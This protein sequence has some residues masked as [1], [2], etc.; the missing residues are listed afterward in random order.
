MGDKVLLGHAIKGSGYDEVR[1]AL[2]ILCAQPATAAHVSRQLAQFYVADSPPP[3]L[4]KR[5]VARWG[6]TGGDIAELLNLLFHSPEFKASLAHPLLKDPQH[7]VLSAVRMAY[8]DR[9]IANTQPVTNWLNRLVQPFYGH[10]T[11]DGYPSERVAWNGPGQIEQR[12]EIAQAIGSGSAGL[13]KGEAPAS[14]AQP[15]FPVLQGELYYGGLD[16]R[17]APATRAA[18][19]Q[20]TSP[21]EWNVFFLASPDFMGR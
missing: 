11:P 6:E 14:V 19:A 21:Q 20:A 17:L 9:V 13:F 15:A 3:S 16:Q 8:D 10:L 7:Y 12:F 1:Q 18:L 5:M 4:V 2:D